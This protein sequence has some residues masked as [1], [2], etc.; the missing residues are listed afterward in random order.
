[1]ATKTTSPD[2]HASGHAP[3]VPVPVTYRG[4]SD[5]CNRAVSSLAQADEASIKDTHPMVF[6]MGVRNLNQ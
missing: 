1:M 3:K 2:A 4:I 5:S 6:H